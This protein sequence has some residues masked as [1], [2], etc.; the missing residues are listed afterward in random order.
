MIDEK[1]IS[2][3]DAAID[4]LHKKSSDLNQTALLANSVG[5]AT[6]LGGFT[7]IIYQKSQKK[8]APKWMA[9]FSVGSAITSIGA[10]VVSLHSTLKA[11]TIDQTLEKIPT[12]NSQESWEDKVKDASQTTVGIQK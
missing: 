3:Q 12:I 8:A 1:I 2:Q 11:R 6:L 4:A 9:Y 10:Y 5:A 7:D